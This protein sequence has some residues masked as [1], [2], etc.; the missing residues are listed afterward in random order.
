MIQLK[1]RMEQMK[2][3]KILLMAAVIGFSHMGLMADENP[4]KSMNIKD[5][6]GNTVQIKEDGS[7]LIQ[8]ADGTSIEI[9]PNG[10]KLIR[11]AN[12]ASI[13]IKTDGEKIIH[14]ADGTTID[15]KPGDK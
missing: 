1:P 10:E 13:E 4:V 5:A 12:G 14:K 9:K 2:N 7:K 6:E 15:V 3:T 11:E 8:K